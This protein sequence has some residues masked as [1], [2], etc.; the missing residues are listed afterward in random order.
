M[1]IVYMGT[2]QFAVEGL[3]KIHSS[4]H[5][6]V[7]VVTSP[8]KPAGRGYQV[9]ESEI[10][11]AAIELGIPVLQPEKL[12]NKKFLNEL[13]KF[14]AELFVVVAFRKLPP[15]V[16]QI[17]TKGT[18]NLHASLLPQYRGA[19]PI[20][21]AMINGEKTTGVTT[22][23]INENIDTG[24]ILLQKSVEILNED[25]LGDLHDKLMITGGQLIIE[26]IDGIANNSIQPQKQIASTTVLK[27]A[28]K[29]Y[30][31]TCKI[32]WQK[33]AF[34]IHNLIR[35]L[36]PYP[37]AFFIA[38][39]NGKVL[40]IKIFSSEIDEENLKEPFISDNKT[41]WK[42]KTIKGS[43]NILE[44]QFPGKKRLKIKELLQGKKVSSLK[45]L[46]QI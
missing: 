36:S 17:P 30:T 14:Q 12:K 4:N 27:D 33:S 29:I 16:W 11:K 45:I 9:Q 28:P 41:Y 18:F 34:E 2:P 24:D 31:D 26:T 39:E 8:D 40:N 37:G 7:A 44:V 5:Q 1:K 22:F 6:I 15:E 13:I 38:E 21:W 10:K 25:N 32:N 46:N 19:A 23:F 3:K 43:L 20:N 42:I 35:G